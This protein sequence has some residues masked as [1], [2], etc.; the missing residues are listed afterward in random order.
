MNLYI[1]KI[2]QNWGWGDAPDESLLHKH[3]DLS[4]DPKAHLKTQ[5]WPHML[6]TPVLW[7][8]DRRTSRACW[9]PVYSR[10]SESPYFRETRQRVIEQDT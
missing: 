8:R 2:S 9:T 4:L 6:I 5:A 3:T 10:F 1:W 7:G